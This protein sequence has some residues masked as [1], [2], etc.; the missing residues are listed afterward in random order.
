MVGENEEATG[1]EVT[2]EL[3]EDV[4]GGAVD[5]LLGGATTE[6]TNL[7]GALVRAIPVGRHSSMTARMGVTPHLPNTPITWTTITPPLNR[8]QSDGGSNG[9]MALGV[10]LRR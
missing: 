4:V 1:A 2:V 3:D 5:C 8:S 7:R 10:S 9:R 6:L